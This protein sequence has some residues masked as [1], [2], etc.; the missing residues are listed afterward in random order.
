MSTLKRLFMICLVIGAVFS[1]AAQVEGE[2]NRQD[3]LY[4]YEE[5]IV[6]D[7][8]YVGEMFSDTDYAG[9]SK[10]D[11]LQIFLRDRGV[12]RLYYKNGGIYLTGATEMYR[13]D[14]TDLQCLLSAT[15]YEEY[16]KAK[17]NQYISI[18]LFVAGGGA[19][20]VAGVGLYQFCATLV[21]TAK[22]NRHIMDDADYG[23]ALLWN[24]IGGFFLCAGGAVVATACIAPA[25]VMTIRSKM[26]INRIVDGFN[27]TSAI[28]MQLRFGPTPA[29]A[30]VTISF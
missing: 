25:V 24:A 18:P 26:R 5:E 20:A 29:G 10:D 21:Q 11:L 4:I 13:L 3:T 1:A 28:A 30:G 16:R 12:G 15:D 6:Y 17:R 14:K 8:L 19:V 2:G 22:Y 27:A 9:M 7:T 23:S